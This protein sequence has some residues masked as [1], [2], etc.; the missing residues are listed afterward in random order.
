MRNVRWGLA[1]IFLLGACGGSATRASAPSA[2][3]GDGHAVLEVVGSGPSA[4]Y[5]AEALLKQA[6]LVIQIDI[7]GKRPEVF[8]H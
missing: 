5:A 1:L 7:F 3:A 2:P 6:N 4:F 8:L